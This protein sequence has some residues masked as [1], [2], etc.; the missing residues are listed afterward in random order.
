MIVSHPDDTGGG[1]M[2]AGTGGAVETGIMLMI[3]TE[4]Q[5]LVTLL[6]VDSNGRVSGSC[7][8]GHSILKFSLCLGYQET[9]NHV[10]SV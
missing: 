7:G 4:D 3:T 1:L 10:G 9:Q 6:M 8:G 2:G 5:W